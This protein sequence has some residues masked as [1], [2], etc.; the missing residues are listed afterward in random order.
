MGLI[1][2]LVFAGVAYLAY[3]AARSLLLP[4]P[5]GGGRTENRQIDDV[6]VKCPEC[7]IYFPGRQGVPGAGE[8]AGQFFCGGKC[9][10]AFRDKVRRDQP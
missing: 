4:G 6:M 5:G 3:R 2:L 10:A 1:R 7:G 8:Q 9:R